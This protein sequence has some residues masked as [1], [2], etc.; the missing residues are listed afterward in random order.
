[1]TRVMP[2]HDC[3]ICGK[4]CPRSPNGSYRRITCSPECLLEA[5]RQIAHDLMYDGANGW[6]QKRW[7]RDEIIAAYQAEAE[8][9]GYPPSL[10]QWRR[11]K[12][13]LQRPS[14]QAVM[15]HF[16]SWNALVAA[17]GFRPQGRGSLPTWTRRKIVAALKR[18]AKQRG[19]TPTMREWAKA[20]SSHPNYATVV[21]HFGSWNAAIEAAGLTLRR[22]SQRLTDRVR[23]AA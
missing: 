23:G 6:P 21:E 16:G 14:Q 12:A 8:R 13:T 2:P 18:E 20:T 3:L 9:L 1:M 7:T 15:T 5:K 22:P 17:A 11:R 4:P 19:R 10:E